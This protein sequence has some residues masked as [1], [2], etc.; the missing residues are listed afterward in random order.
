LADAARPPKRPNQLSCIRRLV[1]HFGNSE[2]REKNSEF[3]ATEADELEKI[4]ITIQ[5][6][7]SY[8][9]NLIPVRK[10]SMPLFECDELRRM[11]DVP[12]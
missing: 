6:G 5:R 9:V 4:S 7:E 12:D 11:K 1:L 3:L 10:D 8:F 2:M